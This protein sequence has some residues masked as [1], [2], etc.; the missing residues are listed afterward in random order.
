MIKFR[1]DDLIIYQDDNYLALNKPAG[2]SSLHERVVDGSSVI[3][4]V[5]KKYPNYQLCHRIDKETS[6][7]LLLAKNAAAY[8][9]GNL[10]FEQRKVEKIYHAVAQGVHNFT[11]LEVDLPLVT[12]RSGRSSVNSLKGKE[13]KT[14]FNSLEHFGHYTL[15]QAKPITGRLH[16]IRM[17]LASQHAPIAADLLYGAN[18]PLLSELKRN[19]SV[20]KYKEEK[21]MITRVALHAFQLTFADAKGEKIHI[22]APYPKDFAVL[23]KLLRKYDASTYSF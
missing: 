4:R 14:I 8:K 5:Q 10:Q 15:V 12:T 22:E 6:G 16:Q 3:E 17:H 11:D 9:H 13:S 20:G 19:Y 1:L 7:V 18:N 23:I 2:I 21:P